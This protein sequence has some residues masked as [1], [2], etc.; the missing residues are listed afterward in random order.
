MRKREK[1]IR[2]SHPHMLNENIPV[3]DGVTKREKYSRIADIEAK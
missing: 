1:S 3:I 2:T